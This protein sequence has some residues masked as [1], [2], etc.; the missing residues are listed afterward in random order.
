MGRFQA[1]TSCIIILYAV[2]QKLLHDHETSTCE[3][4]LNLAQQCL[5]VLE[6][7]GSL[8]PVAHK[9]H[10]TLT[11]SYNA[12]ANCNPKAASSGSALGSDSGRPASASHAASP[13]TSIQRTTCY[14]LELP[15]TALSERE[16]L[17]LS[18]CIML[19]QLFQSPE[20]KTNAEDNVKLHSKLD[21]TRCEYAQ[22]VERLDW[23]FEKKQP[24]QWDD[25]ILGGKSALREFLNESVPGRFLGSTE[26]SG[27]T[28]PAI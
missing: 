2:A 3:E 27:W 9:F 4:D 17:T 6:F 21:P 24:F 22:M 12:L 11:A 23:D 15:K 7:C 13:D 20:D 19:C 16:S 28:S 25:K 18:L 10:E 26:P 14:L 8:D 5:S 1:Y